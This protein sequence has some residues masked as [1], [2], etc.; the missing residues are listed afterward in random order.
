[1]CHLHIFYSLLLVIYE[2]VQEYWAQDRILKY[3]T[4]SVPLCGR[5]PSASVLQYYWSKLTKKIN[6]LKL[7]S[8]SF[9]LLFT[10]MKNETSENKS[11]MFYTTFFYKNNFFP[12]KN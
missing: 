6:L 12:E 10:Q 8:F 9:L 4:V 2:D 5:K 11:V 7:H 3:L 1:M